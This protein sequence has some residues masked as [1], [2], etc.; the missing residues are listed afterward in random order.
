MVHW[1]FPVVSHNAF[2]SHPYRVGSGSYRLKA[3]FHGGNAGSNPAGDAKHSERLSL[4][5]DADIGEIDVSALDIPDTKLNPLG[6][7]DIGEIGITGTGAAVANAFYHAA[8]RRV[9]DLPITSD[10]LL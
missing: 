5:S 9:R 8:A 6:A 1:L 4:P 7:R 3:P 2:R 10:K